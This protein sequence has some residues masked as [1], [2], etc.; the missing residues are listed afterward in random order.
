MELKK[1]Y[2]KPKL[3]IIIPC[4]NTEAT[5]VET[6]ESVLKQDFDAWEAIIVND[7]SKDNLEEIALK[8]VEKDHR[9]KYY[10]K[11]NGGLGSARNY[12]IKRAFG[13]YILPLDSDNLIRPYFAKDAISVF[14]SYPDIGVIYG[15]AEYFG[16]R[17]GIWKVGDF[18]LLRLLRGN[19]I[20]ACALIKKEVF[21]NV[22]LYDIDIPFQG[23][24]DWE[25]WLRVA[26]SNCKFYYLDKIT[27]DYR[28]HEN[29]MIRSFKK[30]M[31]LKN[32][33]YIKSKHAQLYIRFY[34]Q[35]YDSRSKLLAQLDRGLLWMIIN[36]IRKLK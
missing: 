9:F 4:Y 11:P 36:K 27:F 29:S 1:T 35:L 23:Q 16:E 28:V 22:G 30:E 20:D 24:E 8:W 3:S 32:E 14:E 34:R 18:D 26:T 15:N 2:A 10:L 21:N 31:R 5:L 17:T 25:F 19:Y 13:Q 12:G 6:L 7:S 33:N